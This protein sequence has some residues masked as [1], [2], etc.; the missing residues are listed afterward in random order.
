MQIDAGRLAEIASAE[1]AIDRRGGG[2]D[3][4]V[5]MPCVQQRRR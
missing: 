1:P 4:H 2:R 5:A 3:S